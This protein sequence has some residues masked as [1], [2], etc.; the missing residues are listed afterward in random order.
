MAEPQLLN[1]FTVTKQIPETDS[2]PEL[3]YLTKQRQYITFDDNVLTK[4]F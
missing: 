3:N 1:Q 2:Q 4:Y